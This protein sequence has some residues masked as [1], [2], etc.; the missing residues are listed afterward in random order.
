MQVS[1]SISDTAFLGMVELASTTLFVQSLPYCVAYIKS[2]STNICAITGIEYFPSDNSS[3][4]LI[5]IS[6]NSKL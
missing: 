3:H 2:R 5:S 1:M 6:S 4:V